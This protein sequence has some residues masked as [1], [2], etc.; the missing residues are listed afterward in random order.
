MTDKLESKSEVCTFAGYPKGTKGWLL[1]NPK[2]QKVFVST[3]AIFLEEDY[4]IDQKFLENVILEEI[5]EK[6][7]PNPRMIELKENSP[8][9][10]PVVTPVHRRSGRIVRPYDRLSF[11][12]KSYKAIPEELK[13]DPYN[14]DEAIND[15]DSGRWQDAMK[16]EMESMYSNQVWKLVDLLVNIKHS[17]CKWVYKRKKGPDE[18]VE[19][20]KARLVA[21]GYTKKAGINYKETSFAG[22]HAQ[23]C[24]DTF[25]HCDSSRL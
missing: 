11:L 22:S 12:G 3:N 14:Y 10:D 23:V 8:I 20:F 4:M 19:T 15:I 25:I 24:L 9:P 18:K 6:S 21:K 2:E 1:Y 17:G 7:I 16:A 5:R 13:Q